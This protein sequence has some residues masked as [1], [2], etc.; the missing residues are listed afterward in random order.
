MI[1]IANKMQCHVFTDSF[2]LLQTNIATIK[3]KQI[4]TG[5]SLSSKSTFIIRETC[6]NRQLV[7]K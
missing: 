5:F 7:M 1:A 6:L 4:K 3:S 2:L